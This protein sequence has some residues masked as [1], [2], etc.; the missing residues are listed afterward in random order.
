MFFLLLCVRCTGSHLATSH[1]HDYAI[2]FFLSGQFLASCLCEPQ[3]EQRL[4]FGQV[5]ALCPAFPQIEHLLTFGQFLAVWLPEPHIEQ[6][7]ILDLLN[8]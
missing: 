6:A 3:I 7:I 2:Y 4:A 1:L 8:Y 5:C